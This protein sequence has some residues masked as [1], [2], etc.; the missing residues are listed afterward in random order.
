MG[1]GARAR[2]A[3]APESAAHRPLRPGS[4]SAFERSAR[5]WRAKSD[6]RARSEGARRSAF[7][8]ADGR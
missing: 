3:C 1:S 8:S 4:G 7:S 5:P 6:L 2:S